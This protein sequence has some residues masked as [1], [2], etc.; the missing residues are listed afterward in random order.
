MADTKERILNTAEKFFA[1]RGYG[2]TSLRSIIAAAKVN[3][4]AVHY[5]FRTKEALLD[6]V[7]KRRLEPVNRE[8]LAMLDEFEK[9]AGTMP[10]PLENV[11]TALIDPPLRLAREPANASFVKLMG[12]IHADGDAVLIRKHFG[13]VVERF[14]LAIHRAVPDLATDELRWRA[15]FGVAILA[16]TLLG[17]KTFLGVT[18]DATTERLVTFISAGFRAPVAAETRSRS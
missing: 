2:A 11:L 10:A 15:Y 1:E 4:A 6:A 17:T 13:A 18:G 16:H 3:L 5:H 14:L 12:R 9:A 8:R 7:L